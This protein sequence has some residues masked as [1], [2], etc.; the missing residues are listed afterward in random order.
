[1]EGK[2]TKE[3]NILIF[4]SGSFSLEND[5]TMESVLSWKLTE[6]SHIKQHIHAEYNGTGRFNYLNQT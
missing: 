6:I 4:I 3:S 5:D 2:K 1:M